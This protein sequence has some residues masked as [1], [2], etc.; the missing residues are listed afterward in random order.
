MEGGAWWVTV[1]GLR[2]IGY[3]QATKHAHL[4]LFEDF[5]RNRILGSFF[6]PDFKDIEILCSGIQSVMDLILNSL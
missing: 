6:I 4:S 1:C 5:P 3:H 2:R